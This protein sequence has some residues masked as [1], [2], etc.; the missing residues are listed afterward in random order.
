[1]G[2]LLFD[3][4][5]R[6]LLGRLGDLA[7]GPPRQPVQDPGVRL[8]HRLEVPGREEVALGEL[9]QVLD[10]ALRFGV[11]PP[12]DIEPELLFIDKVLKILRIDDVPG[13]LADH[14]QPVLVD[15]QLLGP[16]AKIVETRPEDAG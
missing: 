8:L 16:A 10:L 3:E 6:D 15:H 11:G 14:H 1:M 2:P 13:V 7:V 4:N 9:H 12:A 5:G